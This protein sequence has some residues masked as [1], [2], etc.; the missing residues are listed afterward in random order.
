[1]LADAHEGGAKEAVTDAIKRTLK[2]FGNQFGLSLYDKSRQHQNNQTAPQQQQ[3]YQQQ[4][5]AQSRQMPSSNE[6]P[7]IDIDEDEVPF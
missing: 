6:V 5:N 2:S 3:S 1:M 4:A 7:V